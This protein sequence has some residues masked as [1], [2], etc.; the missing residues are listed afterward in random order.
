MST[1]NLTAPLT[2]RAYR[3]QQLPAVVTGGPTA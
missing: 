2:A 3:L 1:T